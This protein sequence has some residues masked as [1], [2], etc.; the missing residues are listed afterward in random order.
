MVAEEVGVGAYLHAHYVFVVALVYLSVGAQ[1]VQG[2]APEVYVKLCAAVFL[3]V[4]EVDGS[5]LEVFVEVGPLGVRLVFL[6]AD[7]HD[8]R[9]QQE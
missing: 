4:L 7:G 3:V 6:G 9:Q 1:I 8:G 5:L 2:I